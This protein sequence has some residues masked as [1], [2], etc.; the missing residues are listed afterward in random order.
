MRLIIVRHG[1][2]PDNLNDISQGQRDT[3]L[4]QK[5][6]EQAKRLAERLKNEKI[7]FIYSS[8][9]MRTK[10]TLQE[11]LKFHNSP[12]I[13]SELM[14]ERANGHYEGG[15]RSIFIKER[16]ESGASKLV[17]K[18][19]SGESVVDMLERIKN[20]WASIKNK[21]KEEETIL[22]CSHALWIT[23]FIAYLFD[24]ISEEKVF[25]QLQNCSLTILEITDRP[26]IILYNCAR[27][28]ED[29]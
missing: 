22:L 14:R 28:L 29:K 2:T 10:Q 24:E 19:P 9:L 8:D 27:H 25:Q 6:R 5:G 3:V 18:S 21:H 20:F 15:P 23:S 26:E 4:T 16:T 12:V 7:D 13:Y 17:F 1:E 11:I